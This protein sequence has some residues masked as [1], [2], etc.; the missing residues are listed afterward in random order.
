MHGAV[1]SGLITRTRASKFLPLSL[2]LSRLLAGNDNQWPFGQLDLCACV[3]AGRTK[4]AHYRGFTLFE[5]ARS[6]GHRTRTTNGKDSM[7]GLYV[8][9]ARIETK[10]LVCRKIYHI[11]EIENSF[12]FFFLLK[13]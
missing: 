3:R 5:D 8:F 11:Q 4:R 7:G 13:K 10:Y 9:S 6:L 12:V 1:V 2:L